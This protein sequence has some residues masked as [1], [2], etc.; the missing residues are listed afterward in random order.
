MKAYG[1]KIC[2]I[3]AGLKQ[4]DLAQRLGVREQTISQWETLRENITDRR[5]QELAHILQCE[6]EEIRYQEREKVK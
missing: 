3:K 2:R 4:Y 5:V 6:P 1:L